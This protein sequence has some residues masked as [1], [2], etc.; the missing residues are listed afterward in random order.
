MTKKEMVERLQQLLDC[1]PKLATCDQEV[2]VATIEFL[3]QES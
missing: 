2:V 3:E 1:N